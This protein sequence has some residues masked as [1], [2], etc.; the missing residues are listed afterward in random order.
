M[1]DQHPPFVRLPVPAA[2]GRALVLASVFVCAACGLVY[3]L[4]LVA[5]A[6]Y[7]VG[8]SVTQASVVLSVM[9]V[10]GGPG[11]ARGRARRAGSP[12]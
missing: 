2:L 4:E 3:E 7:L 5:L 9:V 1:I 6:S 12:G 10:R 11:G 8:D